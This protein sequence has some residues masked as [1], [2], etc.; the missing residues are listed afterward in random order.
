MRFRTTVVLAILAAALG[1]FIYL[2]EQKKPG[3][4]ESESTS[5]MLFKIKGEDVVKLDVIGEKASF[6]LERQQKDKDKWMIAEPIRA[7]ANDTAAAEMISRLEFLERK[8]TFEGED[9]EKLASEDIGLDPALITATVYDKGGNAETIR[10]GKLAPTGDR[11]YASKEDAGNR[12]YTIDDKIYPSFDKTLDEIRA[13]TVIE[14][15]ESGVKKL[16]IAVGDAPE[17]SVVKE[18]NYW[19]VA[20]PVSTRADDEKVNEILK[21]LKDLKVDEYVSEKPEEA[22]EYGLDQPL[23]SVSFYQDEEKATT[24]VFAKKIQKDEEGNEKEHAYAMV[25]GVA[26]I[27]EVPASSVDD[28]AAPL[29]E[30]RSA[31][32]IHFI[33][34]SVDEFSI[35]R[36]EGEYFFA[37]LDGLWQMTKP[38][39]MPCEDRIVNDLLDKVEKLEAQDFPEDKPETLSDFG[40]DAPQYELN[41]T[42]EEDASS[43]P[44]KGTL[45]FGK[46][47]EKEVKGYGSEKPVLKKLCYA[48]SSLEE[49][50]FGVEASFLDNLAKEPLYFRK[51]KVL[52]FNSWD[53]D[54]V[55]LKLGQAEYDLVYRDYA[56]RMEKPAKAD[57]NDDAV[58]EL[59]N[60]LSSL[61]AQ[62]FLA[63]DAEKSGDFGLE[64]PAAALVIGFRKEEG[65]AQKMPKKISIG[66]ALPDGTVVGRIDDDELIFAVSESV[67][68]LMKQELHEVD[69]FDF[70][71]DT[72][73][74]VTIKGEGAVSIEKTG[75][76]WNAAQPADLAVS[77]R[78]TED[79]IKKFSRLKTERFVE[80]EAEDVKKYGLDAPGV[81]VEFVYPE[82]RQMLLVG[83]KKDDK[84]FAKLEGEAGVFYLEAKTIEELLAPQNIFAKE[85][86]EGEAAGELTTDIEIKVDKSVPPDEE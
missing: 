60:K 46:T 78:K 84:Y 48:K 79:F 38:K 26:S 4:Y 37:K 13:K 40:L 55:N 59:V 21:K 3:T 24:V 82:G 51:K 70:K 31:K 14:F 58:G 9:Y 67:Y 68:D 32:L 41:F 69:I 2:Y 43:E 6:T 62:R 5:K 74:R 86:R 71:P 63:D 45:F 30:I 73:T 35:S 75:E 15:A 72:V 57:A 44:R 23:C 54:S 47:Y 50:I 10:I 42:L 1:L 65:E 83:S 64:E 66:K 8:K 33:S 77:L 19:E 36:R 7:R 56:W 22:A 18:K 25:K 11:R 49:P 76:R 16:D 80:Y 39:E 81:T 52:G 34:Y 27:Y 28:F 61:E 12:I 20:R 53:V 17:I 85:A 29:G